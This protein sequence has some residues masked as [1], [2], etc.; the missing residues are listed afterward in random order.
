M[1]QKKFK[2]KDKK[3][4]DA[5]ESGDLEKV[6]AL[7]PVSDPKAENSY[8][9][10]A[11]SLRDDKDMIELLLPHSDAKAGSSMA[12][13]MAAEGS[14]SETVEL[15]LPHSDL[16]EAMLCSLTNPAPRSTHFL[17]KYIPEARLEEFRKLVD[18]REAPEFMPFWKAYD[19]KKRLE[20][21]LPQGKS[22]PQTRRITKGRL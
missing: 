18:W 10:M 17:L 2:A 20:K 3:F 7:L 22:K 1:V 8:A 9:L 12:L 15:L 5:V 16:R 14:N 13:Q 19:K 11:S 6:R 21:I 4:F